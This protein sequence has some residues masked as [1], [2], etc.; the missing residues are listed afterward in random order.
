[1]R[2]WRVSFGRN[3]TEEGHGKNLEVSLEHSRVI[4]EVPKEYKRTPYYV[5]KLT[6]VHSAHDLASREPAADAYWLA[7]YQASRRWKP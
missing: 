1:M 2:G 6:N 7:S 3:C 5:E 4:A